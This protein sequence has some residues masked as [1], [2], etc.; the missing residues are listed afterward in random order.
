MLF[1]PCLRQTQNKLPGRITSRR[2][3]DFQSFGVFVRKCGIIKIE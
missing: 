3:K 2:P 1:I